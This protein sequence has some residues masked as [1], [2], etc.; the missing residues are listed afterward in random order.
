MCYLPPL[1]PLLRFRFHPPPVSA[2][3]QS[4]HFSGYPSVPLELT[5]RAQLSWVRNI[6]IY[7]ELRDIWSAPPAMWMGQAGA[8]SV[9]RVTKCVAEKQFGLVMTSARRTCLLYSQRGC[10]KDETES[11]WQERE[12]RERRHV[13]SQLEWS[14]L[15]IL[16]CLSGCWLVSRGWLVSK[17][18]TRRTYCNH[19]CRTWIC[20]LWSHS[21]WAAAAG[22]SLEQH[23][24]SVAGSS[25]ALADKT[26]CKVGFGTLIRLVAFCDICTTAEPVR[27]PWGF[28]SRGEKCF[29]CSNVGRGGDT[30]GEVLFELL[31]SPFLPVW[32][33]TSCTHV[34]ASAVTARPAV[35]F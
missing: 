4:N 20:S 33:N 6:A 32:F 29:P 14:L 7:L 16:H 18:N 17:V 28:K 21:P 9:S 8:V 13:D 10:G 34:S 22:S 11:G 24:L 1:I 19:T 12:G 26:H 35:T 3:Y 15:I 27:T 25:P 23:C 30:L 5:A 31:V 2:T